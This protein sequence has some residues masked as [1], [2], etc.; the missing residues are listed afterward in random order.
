M[1]TK[2]AEDTKSTTEIKAVANEVVD[3]RCPILE[4]QI[5][6]DLSSKLY[7]LY[8]FCEAR[9]VTEAAGLTDAP[10]KVQ[11][12]LE[13]HEMLPE[14]LKYIHERQ[15]VKSGTPSTQVQI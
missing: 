9:K 15:L 1:S 3:P 6:E 13:S 7:D 8:K 12:L 14:I 4:D 5:L 11:K 10:P 2:L